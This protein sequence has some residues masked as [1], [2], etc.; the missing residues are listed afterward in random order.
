MKSNIV[1]LF[2]ACS[3][4]FGAASCNY[5]DVSDELA[6]G[7][8]DIS[9]VFDNVSKTEDWYGQLCANVSDMSCKWNANGVGKMRS[10]Y[11]DQ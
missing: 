4:L 1:K 11:T 6:G 8:T 3:L 2:A 10:L 9:E 7:I 5:L